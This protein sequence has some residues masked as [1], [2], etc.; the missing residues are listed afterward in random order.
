MTATYWEIG[1][2][3]V[4]ADQSGRRRAN[5]GDGLIERQAHDLSAQFGRGF[6]WRNLFQMGSFY[7]AWQGILQVPSAILTIRSADK[8]LQALSANRS[9]SR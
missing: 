1:R 2:R 3:D 4:E 7:L 5:Y 8:N 6:G 9:T